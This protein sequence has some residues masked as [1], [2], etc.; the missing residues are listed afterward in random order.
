MRVIKTMVLGALILP[1]FGVVG[2]NNAWHKESFD[3]I[4]LN[5]PKLEKVKKQVLAGK[6]EK[7][8]QVLLSYFRQ[9]AADKKL[10]NNELDRSVLDCS[11]LKP[12]DLEK[13]EN[14]LLHKF[15]PQVGYGFFDYGKDINWEYWPVKDNEVRWQLHRVYWWKS[16]AIAYGYSKDEKYAAEW[17]FQFRDWV[18]KNK[19][20]LSNENDK[21]AWR[22][23]EVSERVNSLPG[24]F[25]T[26]LTSTHFTPAF[27]LEFLN[28]YS[29]HTDFILPH[30]AERGNHLLFEA[31]R[32]LFAGSTFPELKHADTWRKDG[33]AILKAEIEEQVYPDGMQFELSPHYHVAATDIFLNAYND[34][35]LAGMEEEFPGTYSKCIESMIMATLNF[36]FPD[37]NHPMFGDSFM[38]EKE[39]GIKAFSKWSNSF[40]ANESIKYFA[41]GGKEGNTPHY[42]SK[43]LTSAGFYTFRNGWDNK[44]TVLI[45]KA[46]PPG[47]FHAQPDNGT[48]ELWVKGRNF[49]PD[50]GC[51]VYSGDAEIIKLRDWYR[52]TRVHSTLTLNNEN[53]VITNAKLN[54]WETSQTLDVL[55]YTNP[56]YP[57][58]NHRRSVLFIDKKYFLI[59]DEAIG[60][61]VGQTGIHFVLKEDS[62]PVFEKQRNRVYTSY[63]DNNNLLIQYLNNDTLSMQEEEGKVSY[64]YRKEKARP[65]FVFEKIKNDK[66]TRCFI[67]VLYP[68]SSNITPDISM[69]E[70]AGNNFETGMLNVK[71]MINGK[72]ST[73]VAKLH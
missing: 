49:T 21:F 22:A 56:S 19:F 64:A 30:S 54:T 57:D 15:K 5:F 27:L 18:R 29:E 25:N 46:S 41:T 42:L 31:Q 26:C 38:V 40:P 8:A 39:S 65:A 23:L 10:E 33:I 68:Y 45:L 28:S 1:Y 11:I 53:M 43:G 72:E 36:S 17:I 48:F 61:A 55:C 59:I 52:Q 71:I 7:A 73:V 12:A 3:A 58:L 6:Y 37:Y 4:N 50:A 34:A 14:A 70:N 16:M 69:R 47:R 32:T 51:Y 9:R 44:A 66:K 67:T 13:A 60:E 24:I 63:P 62:R 20:G 2:Q 35:K